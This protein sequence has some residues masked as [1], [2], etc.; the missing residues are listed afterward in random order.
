[1]THRYTALFFML[2]TLLFASCTIEKNAPFGGDII[3]APSTGVFQT[4]AMPSLPAD[5]QSTSDK[6]S[7][8]HRYVDSLGRFGARQGELIAGSWNGD[9]SMVFMTS[10]LDPT[11]TTGRLSYKELLV[12]AFEGNPDTVKTELAF[13]ANSGKNSTSSSS[14][15]PSL[16]TINLFSGKYVKDS[17]LYDADANTR[18]LLHNGIISGSHTSF[19]LPIQS[20]N[21]AFTAGDTAILQ[22]NTITTISPRTYAILTD[23]IK[24]TSDTQLDTTQADSTTL[25]TTIN[26]TATQDTLLD[27]MNVVNSLNIDSTKLIKRDTLTYTPG[28]TLHYSEQLQTIY[29][30]TTQHKTDSLPLKVITLYDTIIHNRLTVHNFASIDTPS[31]ILDTLW[32]TMD[33]I[34]TQGTSALDTSKIPNKKDSLRVDTTVTNSAQT[35]IAQ[36]WNLHYKII[37]ANTL[38]PVQELLDSMS[39]TLNLYLNVA[40]TGDSLLHF[41]KPTIRIMAIKYDTTSVVNKADPTRRDTTITSQTD[42]TWSHFNRSTMT[43]TTGTPLPATDPVLDGGLEVF[44]VIKLN[45]DSLWQIVHDSGYKFISHAILDLPL[46]QSKT[47]LPSYYDSIVELRGIVLEALHTPGEVLQHFEDSAGSRYQFTTKININDSIAH[48]D[49]THNLH[50]LLREHQVFLPSFD[51]KNSPQTYLYLWLDGGDMGRV[52]WKPTTSLSL[53][54]ILQQ[55]N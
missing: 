29:Y 32:Y 9:T 41:S 5:Y 13:S 11:D 48:I 4:I 8:L 16:Y 22:T 12:K 55:S 35:V 20:F 26:Y 31:T 28:K 36:Q 14:S 18:T 49:L 10:F 40:T 44:S 50:D 21:I 54:Y 33:T 30:D 42:T 39:D 19:S 17:T 51:T 43:V 53:T 3:S 52:Y 27:W 46:D 47:S 15:T 23:T 7:G 2:F 45:T 34:N 37:R 6:Y 24:W 1:M 38:D 25:D